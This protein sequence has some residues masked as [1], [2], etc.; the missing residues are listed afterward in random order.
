MA[1]SVATVT[2]SDASSSNGTI[3]SNGFNCSCFTGALV[4]TP[5]ANIIVIM[6][7]TIFLMMKL[8]SLFYIF[9]T[10]KEEVEDKINKVITTTN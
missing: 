8:K 6:V 5:I 7:I 10:K 1:P 3:F 2:A 9:K 4:T